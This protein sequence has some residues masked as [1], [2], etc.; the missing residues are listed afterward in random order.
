[1][2]TLF[3]PIPWNVIVLYPLSNNHA[4]FY[5]CNKRYCSLTVFITAACKPLCIPGHSCYFYADL[6]AVTF[7]EARTA[8]QHKGANLVAFETKEE[9]F[10]FIPWMQMY[11]M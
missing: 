5:N 8:C 11:S 6:N 2:C 9:F 7:T 10:K 3:L 1:M 4:L